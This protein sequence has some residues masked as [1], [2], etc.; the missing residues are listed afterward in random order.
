MDAR[1]M[2]LRNQLFGGTSG[3]QMEHSNRCNEIQTLISS[4]EEF[5]HY[6]YEVKNGVPSHEVILFWNKDNILQPDHSPSSLMPMATSN[7]PLPK[8]KQQKS[9]SSDLSMDAQGIFQKNG[10]QY[11]LVT[12][13]NGRTMEVLL[14]SAPQ[15]VTTFSMD[16]TI[17][18]ASA[19]GPPSISSS[20]QSS[21]SSS[22]AEKRNCPEEKKKRVKKTKR[23]RVKFQASHEDIRATSPGLVSG[24]SQPGSIFDSN[25]INQIKKELQDTYKACSKIARENQQE[26]VKNEHASKRIESSLSYAKSKG[27]QW[28]SQGGGCSV[29]EEEEIV[30]LCEDLRR[31]QSDLLDNLQQISYEDE[32]RRAQPRS[33]IPVYQGNVALYKDFSRNFEE[34]VKYKSNSE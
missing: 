13:A 24:A 31:V 1:T 26:K 21:T 34:S 19:P 6:F 27:E 17:P 11:Q 4:T 7:E 16:P 10:Q 5:L 23:E 12:L 8:P 30:N 28:I 18:T 9:H 20:S 15:N 32:R 29:Q 22:E 3:A 33:S 2:D 25:L 14:D